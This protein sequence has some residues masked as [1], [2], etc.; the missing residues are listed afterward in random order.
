M[1]DDAI[2]SSEL[3]GSVTGVLSSIV[4]KFSKEGVAKHRKG[5]ILMGFQ[6]PKIL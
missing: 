6:R 3:S 2:P 4:K 5:R 1:M